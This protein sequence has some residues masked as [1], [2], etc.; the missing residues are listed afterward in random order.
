[1]LF[2]TACQRFTQGADQMPAIRRLPSLRCPETGSFGIGSRPVAAD[3]LHPRMR[4]E[5]GG[6]SLGG[7]D[8]QQIDHAMRFQVHQNGAVAMPPFPGPVI[9]PE[10][11]RGGPTWYRT[12]P[13]APQ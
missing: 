2:E 3:D 12:L 6:E 1:M 9:H 13:H 10:H 4:L 7:T 8:R 11:T 5:P